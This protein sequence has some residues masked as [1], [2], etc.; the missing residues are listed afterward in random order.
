MNKDDLNVVNA[1]VNAYPYE[2]HVSELWRHMLAPM[3]RGACS[4]Y[5]TTKYG[6]LE[7]LGWPVES[8]RLAC[9]WVEPFKLYDKDTGLLR[10]AT[11]DER[12]HAVLLVNFDEQTWVLDNRKP[13]PTEIEL[14]PYKWDILQVAGTELWEKA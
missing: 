7:A 1:K 14:L 11:M 13:Y 2:F 8:L 4:N 12:Y 9:C 3:P 6:R 10:W 5:A